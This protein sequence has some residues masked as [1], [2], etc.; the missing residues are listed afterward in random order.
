MTNRKELPKELPFYDYKGSL[1]MFCGK[2]N[3][4]L[5]DKH[6]PTKNELEN[7]PS[8]YDVNL[9]DINTINT[10]LDSDLSPFKNLLN[11]QTQSRYFS[12]YG[13]C[14]T[15]CKWL[16][17]CFSI[18]HNNVV[19]NVALIVILKIDKYMFYKKLIFILI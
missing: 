3:N 14:Q 1:V 4:S 9:F 6:Q 2:F 18:F 16:N 13:F 12:P 11:N 17:N 5:V 8:L 15:K 19:T 7:L 10:K